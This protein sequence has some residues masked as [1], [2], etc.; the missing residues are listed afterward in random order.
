MGRTALFVLAAVAAAGCSV[1][2][3]PSEER[4]D[5]S[6]PNTTAPTEVI[7]REY[8]SGISTRQRVL[9]KSQAELDAQWAAIYA[10][11]GPRPAAPTVDF[12]TFNVVLASMGTKSSGGYSIDAAVMT[13]PGKLTVAVTETVPGNTCGTT[14][15]LT[16]PAVLVKVPRADDVAFV[17]KTT[18][19]NCS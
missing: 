6:L 19:T 18:V 11:F 10:N 7:A 12:N 5:A 3:A 2:S 15:A 13:G 4:D 14:A 8:N 16:A 9:I 1:P 17:E